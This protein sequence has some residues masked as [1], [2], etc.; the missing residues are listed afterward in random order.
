MAVPV[1]VLRVFLG[2]VTSFWSTFVLG[3][4]GNVTIHGIQFPREY[5]IIDVSLVPMGH[6]R[7]WRVRLSWEFS[8][9]MFAGFLGRPLSGA[10]FMTQFVHSSWRHD[11]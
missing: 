11:M 2:N 7:M 4:G 10:S 1:I 5:F 3:G 8:C 6:I 9:D